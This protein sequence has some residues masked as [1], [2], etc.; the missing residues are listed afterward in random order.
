MYNI[1]LGLP[2]SEDEVMQVCEAARFSEVV[3]LLPLGLHTPIQEKG[4]NLSGGQKQRLALARGILAA[5]QSTMILMDEPTSSIDPR[6]ERKIY[7]SM[8]ETFSDKAVISS[9]HRLHLLS[10]FDYIYI[11]RDGLVIDEGSFEDLRRYSLVFKEMCEH[12]ATAQTT[13][14]VVAEEQFPHLNVAL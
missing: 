11:L 10:D 4:V 8:F 9:L 7:Q 5:R 6:T 1:T 14:S 12:Q 13:E 3:K 2:F